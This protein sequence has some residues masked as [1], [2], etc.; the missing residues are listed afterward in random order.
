M[1]TWQLKLYIWMSLSG[2]SLQKIESKTKTYKISTFNDEIE[3][4][5]PEKENNN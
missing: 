1:Y 4:N 3:K 2:E 5:M